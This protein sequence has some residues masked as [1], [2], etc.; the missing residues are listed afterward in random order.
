MRSMLRFRL[1][2]LLVCVAVIA[3]L[4]PVS[5]YSWRR[6]VT[7]RDARDYAALQATKEDFVEQQ[8]KM[9]AEQESVSFGIDD[10]RP[11]PDGFVVLVRK[12]DVFGCFVPLE[13]GVKGESLKYKWYYRTDGSGVLDPSSS[14]VE[15][16]ESFV[17]PYQTGG[18]SLKVAFG[19][20]SMG[21][22]GHEQGWGYLYYDPQSLDEDRTTPTVAIC[23]T[24]Q[25]VV[26]YLDARDSR[27]IYKHHPD[28]A[29]VAGNVDLES[30][31][32]QDRGAE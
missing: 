11:I 12:G 23:A 14:A 18:E 1:R 22:S 7:Y 4:I 16:G 27:W 9:Q 15:T 24:D 8:R 17:G 2:T 10:S 5:Q 13:Q 30:D 29:G 28:D 20:F 6:Y 25:R 21:W 32:A 31:E 3:V 26:D 19:P